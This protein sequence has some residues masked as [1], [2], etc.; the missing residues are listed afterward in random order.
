MIFQKKIKS[1]WQQV[2]EHFNGTTMD[3]QKKKN[4]VVL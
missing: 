2:Y 1:N 3:L 4:G